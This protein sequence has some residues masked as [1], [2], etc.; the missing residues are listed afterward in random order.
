[1]KSSLSIL[2][3]IFI[4]LS[5]IESENQF[6]QTWK[7]IGHRTYG[8]GGDTGLISTPDSTYTYLFNRDGTFLKTVGKET[9]TG[10]YER[11]KRDY[12]E[13]GKR[14]VYILLFPDGKLAHSCSGQTEQ[15]FLDNDGI[16]SGG[17]APCDGPTN[18]F[19]IVK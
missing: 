14:T 16:L 8:F 4:M 9:A 18:Y 6:P 5:C 10:T 19:E 12:Q 13:G 11:E 3:L 1:M 2:L 15:L 17:S 7:I